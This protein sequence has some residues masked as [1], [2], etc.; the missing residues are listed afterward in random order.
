[1]TPKET[2]RATVVGA[3]SHTTKLSG[4]TVTYANA[5]FPYR[6]LPV[7][8]LTAAEQTSLKAAVDK[9]LQWFH[10]SGEDKVAIYL[11][12][13]KNPTF[14]QVCALADDILQ[15]FHEATQLFLITKADISKA[16]GQGI[17]AKRPQLEL[18]CMDGLT[19]S[20]GSYVDIGKPVAG[21]TALPVVI[22]TL[23]F[24]K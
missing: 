8:A 23:I 21:G 24:E 1:M 17:L 12:G 14:A 3:G 18:V 7:L 4:S 19:L 5:N 10:E 6:N 20:Q 11:P 9:K 13:Y 22:K 15:V 2:I 16:L